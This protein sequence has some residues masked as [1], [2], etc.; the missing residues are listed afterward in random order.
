M[1]AFGLRIR[2]WTAVVAAAC[3]TSF[4]PPI[5]GRPLGAAPPELATVTGVTTAAEGHDLHVVI[6]ASAS[7]KFQ[8][9]PVR[10]E[11]IVVD[12]LNAKL[13]V[14]AGT[15]H[16]AEGLVDRVRIGQFAPT[17][18]RVVVECPITLH[19]DVS[20][21]DDG[22]TVIVAI[23]NGTERPAG[24]APP[25]PPGATPGLSGGTRP[26]SP[27]GGSASP[28]PAAPTGQPARTAPPGATTIV[29][30]R[31]VGAVRLGMTLQDVVTLL[32]HAKETVARS[33]LGV[34]YLWYV[35]PG[36]SGIG[37][38]TTD[39]GI[40]RQIWVVNDGAYRTAQGLHAGSTDAEVKAAL[41]APSWTIAVESSDK[42]TT[43]MYETLGLWFTVR[44]SPSNPYRNV[45]YR[46][47][48]L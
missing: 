37:V 24:L 5:A 41:G 8:V 30:G 43:L 2:R 32:G 6:H 38:R 4:L 21:A 44:P 9:Q 45:V 27:T 35:A 12:V 31:G 14:P 47:D 17:V 3:V 16:G 39:A 25:P 48:V 7:V 40:V 1:R 26:G 15:V 33:G 22:H 13:G 10:P 20:A 19:F 18:V 36:G 28:A 42:S 34:D 23:P 46:I 11:W 29:P